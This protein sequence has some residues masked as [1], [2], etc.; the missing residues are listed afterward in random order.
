MTQIRFPQIRFPFNA[1]ISRWVG[2]AAASLLLVGSLSGNGYYPP[3]ISF[4]DGKASYEPAGDVD[5]SEVTVNLPLLSGDRIVAQPG[6]RVE[7][8]LGQGNFLRLGENTDVLFGNVSGQDG[9]IDLKLGE[10]VLRVNDSSGYYVHLPGST[11]RIKK[12]GYYRFSVDEQGGSRVI[13]WKGR[14][15]AENAFEESK[16]DGGQQLVVNG[17]SGRFQRVTFAP[18]RDELDLWSDRRDAH[19][20]ASQSVAKV[21][22]A[23]TGVYDLDNYGAWDQ[24]PTYGNVWFPSVSVGWAP[25]RAGRWGHYPSWGWTW[26]SH[27]PWGWLPYHHGRWH[28]YQPYNRWCW[29]PGSFSYWSPARVNFYWGS[30]YVGW[31][32]YGFS[33]GFGHGHGIGHYGGG[34]VDNSVTIVNNYNDPRS[35]LTM[36]SE[37]DFRASRVDRTRVK[38][39]NQS[40][41]GNLNSGLPKSL[42]EGSP[43]SRPRSSF[44]SSKSRGVETTRGERGRTVSGGFSQARTSH[45]NTGSGKTPLGARQVGSASRGDTA[46]TRASGKTSSNRTA[47]GAGLRARSSTRP[48]GQALSVSSGSRRKTTGRPGVT[49]VPRSNVGSLFSRSPSSGRSRSATGTSVG[50]RSRST[51]SRSSLSRRSSGRAI[52]ASRSSSRVSPSRPS[53]SSVR[54]S[55]PATSSRSRSSSFGRSSSPSRSSV[56]RSSGRSVSRPSASRSAPRPSA[57]SSSSRTARSSRR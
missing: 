57:P 9:D 49:T 27:E 1:S 13:V 38:T 43:N 21:G 42:A 55:R 36:V 17:S 53:S 11:V 25:Y 10:M 4:I 12:K 19:F 50:S 46:F 37:D 56:S 16:V 35:G 48:A 40:I 52:G 28:Y 3:R 22:G 30:G 5:W 26:I 44:V 45:A 29:A 39:I 23:Y 15:V 54:S 14:V 31:S 8:E 6:S 20:S 24:V 7:I 2:L 18:E 33:F 34:Y 51:P 41:A 32:P 47:S